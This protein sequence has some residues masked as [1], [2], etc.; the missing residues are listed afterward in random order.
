MLQGEGAVV[1]SAGCLAQRGSGYTVR[2]NDMTL[3]K[4]RTSNF[5]AHTWNSQVAGT[6]RFSNQTKSCDRCCNGSVIIPTAKKRNPNK[7]L[8]MW[9]LILLTCA[10]SHGCPGDHAHGSHAVVVPLGRHRCGVEGGGDAVGLYH[11]GVVDHMGLGGVDRLGVVR[12]LVDRGGTGLDRGN[13][14]A[15]QQRG[16]PPPS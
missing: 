12:P 4:G 9:F 16:L 1:W 10:H 14:R 15:G 7:L 3:S 6:L 5:L 8:A 13:R 2:M 11:R